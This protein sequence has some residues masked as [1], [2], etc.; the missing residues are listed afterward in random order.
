VTRSGETSHEV[1]ADATVTAADFSLAAPPG[2]DGKG[3]LELRNQGSV[4]HEVVFLRVADG[5]APADVLAWYGGG[6]QGPAPFAFTG[7]AAA[8]KAG[9]SGWVDLDLTP[10]TYMAVCFIPTA[11]GTPHALLGMITNFTVA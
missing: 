9:S 10:G 5:K 3:T 4:D 1:H 11:D 2:W 6:Q 8:V 7:G